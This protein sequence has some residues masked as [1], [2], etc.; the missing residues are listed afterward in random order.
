MPYAKELEDTYYPATLTHDDYPE[1]I[2]EGK[3]VD[4]VAVCAVLVSFNWTDDGIRSR[5]IG[6]FVDRFFAN[7]DAFLQ[8]AASPEMAR[9]EFRGD[10]RGLA[11]LAAAQAWIDRAK[12]GRRRGDR[13][14]GDAKRFD[15]F[16]AQAA[17][18]SGT[19][20]SDAERAD[21]FR[22]FIEWSKGQ[23]Q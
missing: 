16:L 3:R 1:L 19:P 10:A 12:G 13:A 18:A 21:L 5:K 20:I 14:G 23:V 6:K 17:P 4:T 8:G 2:D 22:A 9:G 7:F 15:T 11:S